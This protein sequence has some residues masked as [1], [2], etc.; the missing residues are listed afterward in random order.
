MSGSHRKSR[1]C[2]GRATGKP[3]TEYDTAE[4]AFEG[5][6]YVL[7]RYNQD[8]HPYKCNTCDYWHLAPVPSDAR[9][10][11][12]RTT[13]TT[14]TSIPRDSATCRA[15]ISGKILKEYDSEQEAQSSAVYLFE[16]YGYGGGNSN[17]MM[18]PY[19]CHDCLFWHLSPPDRQ[20][21][22]SSY[23]CSCVDENGRPKDGYNT[24]ED[25]KQRSRILRNET[26]QR[27]YVYQCPEMIALTGSFSDDNDECCCWHLTKN[28]PIATTRE[29]ESNSTATAA[30]TS[31][32][33][34]STQCTNRQG[35]F[36]M[37]Y[38]CE[39]D[40]MSGA[41]YVFE[42]YNNGDQNH[43]LL[44]AFQCRSCQKWHIG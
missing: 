43:L 5:S 10:A 11:S 31:R 13:T 27:L 38:D 32:G 16:R 14:T 7:E 19:K 40:A 6:T 17:E 26:G 8:M 35:N 9:S 42:R 2:Y 36:R 4:D 41:Q 30:S 20:T 25:A 44:S 3:L 21:K 39:E 18:V 24:K 34:K 15:R 29:Q 37:E 28:E 1:S 22:H 33:R 23:T 12:S